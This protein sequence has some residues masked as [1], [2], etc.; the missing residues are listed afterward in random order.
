MVLQV[1][2]SISAFWFGSIG[3]CCGV[4]P[5]LRASWYSPRPTGEFTSECVVPKH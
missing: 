3:E 1:R 4:K 2:L 5:A